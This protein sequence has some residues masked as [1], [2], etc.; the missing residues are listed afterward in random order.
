MHLPI[1]CQ[2]CL[3]KNYKKNPNPQ[4]LSLKQIVSDG[5]ELTNWLKEKYRQEKI[6]LAGY[7]WGSLVGVQMVKE[8]PENYKAYFG[9]SQFINKQEGMKISRNWLKEQATKKSDQLALNKI[10]SLE[11]LAFYKDEHDRFFQQYLLVNE[12][13]GAQHNKE[14]TSEI[15]KAETMYEDYQDYDW[16]A[17]W[18]VSSSILQKDLYVADVR[19]ITKLDVPVV[20]FQGR[21]DWNVPSILA[22][23]WLNNL[24]APKKKIIWFENSGHG[25]LEEEPKIFNKSMINI[26]GEID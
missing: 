10:D 17:V 25:P 21:Y 24:Q 8:H 2:L 15:E 11:N 20:L 5:N 19:D 1:F 18:G 14:A 22:E 12:Y 6:Y 9:I 3:N 16:Y 13:G 23:S 7:S 26:L 4:H